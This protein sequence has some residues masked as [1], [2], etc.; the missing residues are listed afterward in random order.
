[1]GGLSWRA[2]AGLWTLAGTLVVPMLV[3]WFT[4]DTP[5]VYLAWP[6]RYLWAWGLC[7][8]VLDHGW[9]P[10]RATATGVLAVSLTLGLVILGDLAGLWAVHPGWFV[11]LEGWQTPVY[12]WVGRL[13]RWFLLGRPGYLWILGAWT[14]VEGALASLVLWRRTRAPGGAPVRPGTLRRR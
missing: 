5:L 4:G 12:A 14:M 3:V 9:L 11:A 6:L 8:P 13:P 1:M 2:W 7:L 10:P